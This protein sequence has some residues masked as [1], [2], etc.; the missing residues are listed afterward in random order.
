MEKELRGKK[1]QIRPERRRGGEKE[2][3]LEL[4]TSL[5]PMAMR[6]LRGMILLLSKLEVDTINIKDRILTSLLKDLVG[7]I[8]RVKRVME[9][10]G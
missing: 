9:R 7:R 5:E 2:G 4:T 8:L 10:G 1:R 6:L 3:F